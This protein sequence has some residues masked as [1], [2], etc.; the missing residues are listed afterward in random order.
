MIAKP[1]P[2]RL[3]VALAMAAPLLS[4]AALA[5][6][7][8]EAG[9]RN[10]PDSAKPHTWWHWMDGNITAEGLTADL[11]AMKRVGIGGAQ[12][13][14][15]SQ[16][17]PPG[18]VGYNSPQ[19]RAMVVHAVKEAN[20]LG[21][22]LC[23]HNCAGWSSSGGPW[24]TPEHAMQ[25][26]AWSTKRVTGPAKL[27]EPLPPAKAPQ[28]V[29]AI[30]YYRDICVLAFR[31]PTAPNAVEPI[32]QILGKTAV[33]RQDGI[34]IDTSPTPPGV[35][36]PASEIVVLTEKMDAN[37][38]LTWDVPPGDWTI[39]RIGHTPTGK[40]NHPAPP[41]GDG[42][43]VD[44][45]SREAL[46]SH[47][48]GMMA[49]VIAELGPLAG[50]TLNNSLL[51]SYEVGSQN[52][53]PKFREAFRK[54][55][56]YDLLPYLPAIA[57]YTVGSRE[58]TSRFLWDFRRTIADLYADNYYGYFGDLCH[59]AGM[60]FSTEPYGNGLFDNIQAGGRADIPMGEFWVGGGTLE[61][62]KLAASVGH[63]YGRKYVGAESFTAD[64]NRG[65]W[66]VEPYGIK[67]LGDLVFCNG[68]NRYIFHRYAHQPWLNLYP[69]MTMG[70]WG[71]HLERTVTWWNDA[72]AW[73]KYVARCQYL[74][75]EGRFVADALYYYG[76]GAPNDLPYRPNLRPQ[77]PAGYDYD[78]CDT[79]TVLNRASVRD[80]R[81]VL[82]DGMTYR[83]LLLPDS[84]FM[85]P[86]VARKIKEL[87]AQGAT[88]VGPKPRLSPS[89]TGYPACDEEVRAIGE[90]VWG[91]VD[92]KTA[93]E[94]AFGRGRVVWGRPLDAVFA[95][96]KAAPDFEAAS[97][98]AAPKYAYIH[99]TIDGAEVY[100]VSNQRYRRA[101]LTCTFRVSGRAP[102]LWHADTGAIE[103][104]P[105]YREE[106]GRTVVPL[107]L[108][109][110]GSVFVVFRR[111][112]APG[113]LT[114]VALR[115]DRAAEKP[116][117]KITIVKARYETADGRG[118][119]VT[120]KVAAMAAAGQTEI[121][122]TNE[123]F[124]DPVFNVVKRLR[125]QYEVDGKPMEKTAPENESVVLVDETGGGPATPAF[126]LAASGSRVAL[127][128]W[129][130][131]TYDFRL[132]N[133]SARSVTAV[134]PESLEVQGPWHLRFPKGW[135]APESATF[136][137]LIS[138]PESAVPGIKY[139][140]GTAAY[141][142]EFSI[143]RQ[144]VVSGRAVWLD[145][146]QVKNLARVRLNGRDLGILWKAP[147]RVNVTG[148]ARPGTNR[149]EVEVTN[150]WPN[151]LIGDE[152]LPPDVEWRGMELA[153][154]PD[155]LV[156][157][158]PR[159]NTG[160]VTFTTWRF[161]T[162]DSPLLES[163][164][165]GPVT[166]QSAETIPLR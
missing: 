146:G 159:P 118:A 152:Q 82:A 19:W 94:H 5:Q 103:P 25:V 147:F 56:G 90:E 18:P 44:K 87:V 97:T 109:P 130:A 92:G 101:D 154:W 9:F 6:K 35:A 78:G 151:R 7:P 37:G 55:R 126:E 165:L 148:I 128:P 8:L 2:Y 42:L 122:A 136:D 46:D 4:A 17:I 63:T 49:K 3:A 12:M 81:I 77:I 88:V 129:K 66:L 143:P 16:G 79:D 96:L 155:W 156:Q 41:E 36:I 144:M 60:K 47:W 95:S 150:L 139:F 34:S 149:L 134:A 162:K 52:W 51:D 45:L 99:R 54:R 31:T 110:A 20:R 21:I 26:L 58:T 153:R 29:K 28:V 108:D 39:L 112:S 33:N 123:A 38:R 11:E 72:S 127:V 13:F 163:G 93:T 145:L 10:P 24:I 114:D 164:L 106:N 86:A 57:G 133:G 70:P 138:W 27:D 111:P 43:E 125:I 32:P 105:V 85:T 30:P 157:H 50:K 121:P 62:T 104:A 132:D 22:E 64:V 124:G 107:H 115:G 69:G 89:L 113:H 71:T 84:E 161:Y 135:G 117:P 98:G 75:Q 68:I 116:A 131:G 74:L 142:K 48:N 80:G 137:R 100:F 65:R 166:L 61:T 14:H 140:S 23:I 120:E 141:T 83:V 1:R 59:K 102:E 15:V 158:K 40:D 53:T 119:D 91:D 67:A 160:R 73:L 76:E